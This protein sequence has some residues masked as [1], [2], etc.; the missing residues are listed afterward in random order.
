MQIH[1]KINLTQPF[2][3]EIMQMYFFLFLKSQNVLESLKSL[4]PFG[5]QALE[6]IFFL[7]RILPSI[8]DSYYELYLVKRVNRNKASF[9]F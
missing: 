3:S 5:V 6:Q 1:A 9:N 4:K 8:R 7:P 2:I